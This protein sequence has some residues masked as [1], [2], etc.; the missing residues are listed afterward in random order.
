[1]TKR[2]YHR[3]YRILRAMY[4]RCSNPKNSGWKNY[5]GRGISVCE[6]WRTFSNFLSDMG[7]CP[8]TLTI[9]RLNNNGNY[10]PG[11]C[12]WRTRKQQQRNMRRN[13]VIKV[14]GITGCI[15]E[16]AE[17]FNIDVNTVH[18][19]LRW[20]WPPEAAFTVPAHRSLIRDNLGRFGHSFGAK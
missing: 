14:N 7:E 8:G 3:I 12:A 13:R 15:S 19:R 4:Q 10:E 17:I 18:G 6:R 9:E 20:G 11:N 1:M 2:V 16:L 5:G